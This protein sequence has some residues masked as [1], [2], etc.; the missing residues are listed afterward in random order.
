MESGTGAGF[1]VL[2]GGL[3]LFKELSPVVLISFRKF[4]FIFFAFVGSRGFE[5]FEGGRFLPEL[6]DPPLINVRTIA[7]EPLQAFEDAQ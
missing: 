3:G 4:G 1:L 7:W 2:V 6:G 5:G